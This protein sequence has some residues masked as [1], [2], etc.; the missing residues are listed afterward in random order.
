MEVFPPVDARLVVAFRVAGEPKPAG[1]K[2]AVP[3]GKRVNGKFIPFTRADGTPVVA[4][5][6]SSGMAGR[7]WRSD[8][9]AACAD[10]LDAAHIL[11]D[12]PLVVR[13]TFFGSR[14]RGDYGTG[15]NAGQ[16]KQSADLYP[17]RSRLA[18]GTKL[19]R[20][21]E[22]ALTAVCWTDDRR[23]V[24]LWWSRRFGNPGA[25]VAIYELP[26]RAGGTQPVREQKPLFAA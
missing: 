18:D 6:D 8:I 7:N 23:V 3:R 12:G 5:L 24:D 19:A 22:D 21:L 13:A 2:N 15:R 1:S 16:L 11:V 9:R 10:A 17:H 26:Q 20:L 25:E 4:V 14:R